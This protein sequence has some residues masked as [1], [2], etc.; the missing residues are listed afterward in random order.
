MALK[1]KVKV[2]SITNLSDARYCAGMGVE[3]LGFPVNGPE[4]ISLERFKEINGWVTGPELVIEIDTAENAEALIEQF[5]INYIEVDASLLS[6]FHDISDKSLIVRVDLSNW[7]TTAS[8]LFPYKEQI[9]Y[10]LVRNVLDA[11]MKALKEA[12]QSY[13]L[14]LEFD[15]KAELEDLLDLPMSGLAMKGGSELKPGLKEYDQI[16]AVLEKLE[17]TDND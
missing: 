8:L 11:P 2:G 4:G 10:L 9:Q 5:G 12:A 7:K 14:L 1:T 3:L 6:D 17:A 13:S 15:G 16:A